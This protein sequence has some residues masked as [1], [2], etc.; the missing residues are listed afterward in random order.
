MRKVTFKPCVLMRIYW[1]LFK[2]AY[3]SFEDVPQIN[4]KHSE[5]FMVQLQLTALHKTINQN[6]AN[7]FL[8]YMQQ[9]GLDTKLDQST[10][11]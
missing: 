1:I 4:I 9:A 11:I 3:H 10:C 8:I 2:L 7:C 6:N 5:A